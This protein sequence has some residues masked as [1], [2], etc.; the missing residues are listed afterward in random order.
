MYRF[1]NEKMNKSG[2]ASVCAEAASVCSSAMTNGMYIIIL[3]AIIMASFVVSIISLRLVI[4]AVLVII[5]LGHAAQG[6]WRQPD[7]RY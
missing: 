3:G 4:L 5:I 1:S 7:F 2:F 6:T